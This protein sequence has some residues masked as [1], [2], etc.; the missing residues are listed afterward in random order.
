MPTDPKF[1]EKRVTA[2]RESVAKSGAD[3]LR[4]ALKSDLHAAGM[5]GDVAGQLEIR[6]MQALLEK[7]VAEV[8]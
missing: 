4:D 8:P 3:V 1:D 7:V 6:E 2:M 5:R